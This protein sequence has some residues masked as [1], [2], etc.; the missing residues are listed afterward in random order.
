VHVKAKE[1][2]LL[3][4]NR[5]KSINF[6][7]SAVLI[8]ALISCASQDPKKSQEAKLAQQKIAAEQAKRKA[9]Q[10]EI[11]KKE[12]EKKAKIEAKKKAEVEEDTIQMQ[13]IS[14][15]ESP[16]SEQLPN[17]G[18]ASQSTDSDEERSA[19]SPMIE[20]A[21]PVMESSGDLKIPTEPNTYLITVEQKK[22][23]QHP[24]FG[25]GDPRGF[26]LNDK[27][28]QYVIAER[29]TPVT[30]KVR[31]GL[32]HD[33]Y[34]S[35]SPKGWGA[36]AYRAG[37]SGQ[38]TY[39]GDVNFTPNKHTPDVLY[40]GCRNHN[41]MGGKIMVVD[42]GTDIASVRA[43]LESERQAMLAKHDEK[44]VATIDARKVKQ[45]IAYVGMLLQFKGKSL[46]Q[47]QQDA[48][49]E[50]I[51]NAKSLE[52]KG[53]LENAFS[54]ILIAEKLFKEK[55][56]QVGP[57][58]EEIAEQ[59][60]HFNDLLITLEAFIDSH[61]A[62]YKQAKEEGRKTVNYDN[63]AVAQLV[64]DANAS[65]EQN[66]FDIA[67]KK[68]KKAERMVTSALNQMLNEQT[69]VYDLNFKTL[70][71]EFK[72]ELNRYNSYA[73]LIP[74]AIDV[75]KPKPSAIKFMETY[76]KKAEF[77]KDKAE[78]SAAA[79]REEEA[80]VIIKDATI[81]MRRGLRILGVSM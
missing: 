41:S 40:Y 18:A 62:S 14:T 33:F 77:F 51:A 8:F 72:Y 25:V 64:L 17:N 45:K 70:A 50:K 49:K 42:Q 57:S 4:L 67:E 10:L 53:E 7:L 74:V 32:M 3:L 76:R 28:G 1:S 23:K 65:A 2:A 29:N 35:E 20:I 5:T 79:G 11:Q 75:K 66:K 71:E 73:E 31:T 48:I 9:Q 16:K 15:V 24:F 12:A 30:F 26:V 80:I 37:V 27:Q 36:A 34:L 78:E 47:T 46:G 56:A 19:A 44:S 6:L 21:T 63:K 61:L 60:E 59:K 54:E 22:P 52:S 58:A 13:S 81:E 68:I 39:N 55:S 43:T 38:F 69:L